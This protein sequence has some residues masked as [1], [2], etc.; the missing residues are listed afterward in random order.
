MPYNQRLTLNL[1]GK[2]LSLEHPVVMG[3]INVTPDSFY[4][5]SRMSGEEALRTRV[6]E[7][8]R[9][10]AAI[11]DVGAYSSRPGAEEVSSEEE[12]RRLT[13]ILRLLRDEYPE[14]PISVDTFRAEVAR[15]AVEEYGATIINDIS[16]GGLDKDMYR[17][18]ADLQVAYILM[19]MRGNP[20]TMG[21]MTD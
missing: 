5:D 21:E 8:I 1:S 16:G 14:L 4:P 3:I 11:A 6:D 18:I 20:K 13:P 9:E 7:L 19:H 15:F 17:T 10:G 2:L 12:R